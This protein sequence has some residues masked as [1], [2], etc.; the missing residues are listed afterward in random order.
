MSSWTGTAERR[1]SALRAGLKPPSER[2]AG[3]MP[4]ESSRRSVR[5]PVRPSAMSACCS[6]QL[7][8]HRGLDRAQVQHQ[9]HQPLLDAVVQ[10]A[11]DLAAGLVTGRN[12]SRT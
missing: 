8:R 5:A 11:F 9:R 6:R 4:R 2:M 3:W 10:V 7:G 1:A 12:E